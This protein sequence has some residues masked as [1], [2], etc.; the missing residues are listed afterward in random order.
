MEG[1]EARS[2]SREVDLVSQKEKAITWDG[3]L[4]VSK[5]K[6]QEV[7]YIPAVVFVWRRRSLASLPLMIRFQI[8]KRVGGSATMRVR[9]AMIASGD[10][11]MI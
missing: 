11:Y 2:T 5:V 3:L 7:L 9:S 4:L 1:Y 10:R 8:T 6:L